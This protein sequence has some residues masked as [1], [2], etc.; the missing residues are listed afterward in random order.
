M[1]FDSQGMSRQ[2][3]SLAHTEVDRANKS[4]HKNEHDRYPQAGATLFQIHLL[5][6]P[7]VSGRLTKS[8]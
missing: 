7:T 5:A 1:S 4:N 8:M 6:R 3:A 2:V